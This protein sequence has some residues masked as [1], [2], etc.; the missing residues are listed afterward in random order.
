MVRR[1]KILSYPQT[2][3]PWL[4]P[5]QLVGVSCGDFQL[6][7]TIVFFQ[8]H[9]DSLATFPPDG[10]PVMP[11]LLAWTDNTASKAW[12]N[13]VSTS[14][15]RGQYLVTI[16]AELLRLHDVGVNCDHVAGKKN[17]LA[18]FISRPTHF[19]LPSSAHANQIFLQ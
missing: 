14:S 17:I 10:I 8:M 13:R 18:D 11:V 9:T 7:A 16:Y 15:T 2:L 4:R 5:N 1:G 6:A 3:R 12:A 19:D